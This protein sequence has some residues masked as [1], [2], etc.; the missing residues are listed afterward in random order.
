ME[1]DF[2]MDLPGI[3]EDIEDMEDREDGEDR[4]TKPER[5]GHHPLIEDLGGDETGVVFYIIGD[6]FRNFA[7]GNIVLAYSDAVEHVRILAQIAKCVVFGQGVGMSQVMRFNDVLL[8]ASG[9]RAI[10]VLH[11]HHQKVQKELVD[12]SLD[13]NVFISS[14]EPCG[15]RSFHS[16]LLVDG[17]CAELSGVKSGEHLQGVLLVEAA[18]QMYMACVRIYNVAPEFSIGLEPVH[19]TLNKLSV[20]FDHFVFPLTARLKLTLDD[21]KVDGAFAH[22]VATIKVIQ[23]DRTC[24]DMKFSASAYTAKFFKSLETRSAIKARNMLSQSRV[25]Y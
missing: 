8:A 14:P 23:F 1:R 11:R 10:R 25:A 7:D 18:R 22:G 13:S 24:C 15:S 5:R 12:K 19:F 21:I 9:T 16:H 3:M 17:D 20:N 4:E 2:A 6:K